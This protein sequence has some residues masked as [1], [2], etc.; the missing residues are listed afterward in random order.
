VRA[1]APGGGDSVRR[2]APFAVRMAR[3]ASGLGAL[4]LVLI[5]AATAAR[6]GHEMTFYPSFY[7][8]EITILGVPPEG[9]AGLLEKKTLHAYVGRDPFR[10][11]APPAH[12][13]RVESLEGYVVLTL[14]RAAAGLADPAARCATAG[15]ALRALAR[16]KGEWVAHPYPVTP[17]HADFVDHFDLVEAAR[18]KLG[19]PGGEG[20]GAPLRVR[21]SGRA[22]E[23]ARAA[24][25]RAP[26]GGWDATLEEVRLRDLLS[27]R[28]TRVNGWSWPP[29]S[30]AG[31]FQAYL[32]YVG[33]LGDVPPA[34][35]V[36]QTLDRRLRGEWLTDGER[37]GLERRLVS[38]VTGG[39]ERVVAGY[40]TRA[41]AVNTDYSE[42]VENVGWDAQSGLDSAMFVRTVKL[43]DFPWNGWLTLGA[44]GHP[45]SA[46][47]PVGGFGD[48]TGRLVWAALT[49]PA[50]LPSPRGDGW[51][52]NRV[53]P[54]ETKLG[55]IEVPGDAVRPDPATG[56]L[57]PVGAGVTARAKVVYRVAASAFHDGTKMNAADAVYPFVFAAAHRRRAPG[58]RPDP[59]V[60]RVA[61]TL[62][63]WLVAFRVLRTDTE[64]KAFGEVQLFY[65]VPVI[66]VYLAH[67]ASAVDL[68][69]IAPPWSPVPWQL[70]ALMD[71]AVARGLGA[72]SESE[73]KRRGIP[74]LDLA[75]DRKVKESLAS[76]AES[77][78]RRSW[79]PDGLKG[80]V[81][82]EQA[83][84]R[85]AA[86]RRFHAKHGHFLVTSGPYRLD[87]WTQDSVVLG[88]FRDLS[89]PLGVGSYDR[90]AVPLRAFVTGVE[91]QRERL[92]LQVDAERVERAGRD[93]KIVREPYHPE[94][95]RRDDDAP[96]AHYAVVGSGGEVAAAGVSRETEG[97]RV[98]VDLRGLAAG[99]YRVL[100]A[101]AI[102]GNLLNPEVKVIPYRVA[103]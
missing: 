41:E 76:L 53:R 101:L 60:E 62:G 71:E 15:R 75:R 35:A 64:I 25:L 82:V 10:A 56:T 61:A 55:T 4:L 3:R 46:W 33:G 24:G 11:A 18:K 97:P 34:P 17:Y 99:E 98:I 16:T 19:G 39:C 49:D 92:M 42:G 89:Y 2:T 26:D 8:Q 37:V 1:P 81:T 7:P 6:A 73:A 36:Q 32:L 47:N 78:E 48:A 68:P 90:Y 100:L 14:N 66:E 43:K 67:G 69:A 95:T 72:Y 83:R 65:D 54:V 13:E 44:E 93:V 87:K 80:L 94:G 28:E 102:N 21:A 88:V 31:W 5:A 59:A 29:W 45:G 63:D 70:L 38:L 77:F 96:V 40:T 9:A 23:L 51:I 30:R 103:D 27:G 20:S 52:P 91:R 57:K 86:L 22:A 12:V 84:Q 58:G 79:V 85:W 74:W 50:L